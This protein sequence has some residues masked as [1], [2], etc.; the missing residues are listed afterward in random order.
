MAERSE[1]LHPVPRFIANA[2]LQGLGTMF[3]RRLAAALSASLTLMTAAPATAQSSTVALVGPVERG[4]LLLTPRTR[5][6]D[7]RMPE[8]DLRNPGEPRRNGLI[9]AIAINPNLDIGVGRFHVGEI[10]RPRDNNERERQP[11]SVRSRDR[12]MAGV[13]FSLR[14]R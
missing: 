11:A 2:I 13:G 10:A 5:G 9:A 1:L 4:P 14:F 8:G 12:A 6:P 3:M 7:F